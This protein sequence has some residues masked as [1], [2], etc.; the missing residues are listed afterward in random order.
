MA[1]ENAYCA[2]VDSVVPAFLEVSREVASPAVNDAA[3]LIGR[4]PSKYENFVETSVVIG[5]KSTIGPGCI[6]AGAVSLAEKCNIK[7]S[8][9]GEG[10]SIGTGVKIVNSILMPRATV[11]DGCTVQGCV[12][13]PRAVVGA[14]TSLRECLVATEYEVGEGDDIRAET[15]ANKSR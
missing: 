2:R 12:V 11:E 10:C 13:G 7:R 4:D 1:P 5:A 3:H 8:V 15:L 14:G 9:I 6:V